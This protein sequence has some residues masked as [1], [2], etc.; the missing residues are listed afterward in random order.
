MTMTRQLL[1]VIITLCFLD[2]GQL[3]DP[4]VNH[5]KYGS[6]NSPKSHFSWMLFHSNSNIYKHP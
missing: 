5:F 3:E 2:D 4:L 6:L 1:L